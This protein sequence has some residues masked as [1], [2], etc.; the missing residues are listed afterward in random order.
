M[1][2]GPRASSWQ[3]RAR[4]A[5]LDQR[6]ATAAWGYRRG[7][8]ACVEPT[9]LAAL[10]L[11]AGAERDAD[12]A[13]VRRSAD[14]LASVQ[15]TDGSLGSSPQTS[16]PGWGTPYALLLWSAVGEHDA[17]RRRATTWLLAQKGE[18]SPRDRLGIV[19]HDTT[20]TGWPWVDHTH[21][22]IEPTALAVLALRREGFGDHPRVRE[23]L[24]VIADRAIVTGGWNCGNKE[25]F[26]RPLRAQP[27]VTGI[28]LLALAPSGER[29]DFV[30]QSLRY[31]REALP[32]VRAA[33]SLGWGLL[34]LRA[35]GEWPDGAEGWLREAFDQVVNRA[36]AAPRL[37]LLLLAAG[38]H[39]L[40]LFHD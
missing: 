10:A 24:R 40:E 30:E 5:L 32:G 39:A 31:L 34:G 18:T 19:G 29:A 1:V 4:R 25:A 36:D 35:W 12:L 7:A 26:G 9:V 23:G 17:A 15:R 38:E 8:S 33:E 37:A 20:L 11:R 13:D 6:Q 16:S 3:P 27:S 21:S 14:W 28:A 2:T 22:W